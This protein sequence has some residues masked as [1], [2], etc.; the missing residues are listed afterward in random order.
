[1]SVKISDVMV[2]DV[3]TAEPHHTVERLRRI[4]QNNHLHAIP[5]VGH[6]GEVKGI[7]SASDLV[8]NV[9]DHTPA[10][11]IMTEEVHTAPPDAD[12]AE[13]A[14]LMRTYEIHHVVVTEDAKIVGMISS[15]DFLKLVEE[16]RFEMTP[17][18][19]E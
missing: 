5:I 19:A 15:F 13:A 11:H 17:A 6:E 16:H 9:K 3:L 8:R 18:A 2:S 1:M 14:R 10:S 4:M 12:V 7:V